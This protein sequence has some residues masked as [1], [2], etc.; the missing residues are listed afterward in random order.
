MNFF[1]EIYDIFTISVKVQ[2]HLSDIFNIMDQTTEEKFARSFGV[3][4]AAGASGSVNNYMRLVMNLLKIF[5][6]E[7]ETLHGSCFSIRA[8]FG[9][10]GAQAPRYEGAFKVK[11]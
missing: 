2:L 4:E 8:G 3:G 10:V 11:I 9:H 5:Y 1:V 7:K 6:L